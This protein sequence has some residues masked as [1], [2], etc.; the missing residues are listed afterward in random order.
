LSSLETLVKGA[1]LAT[2][3]YFHDINQVTQKAT[4]LTA[5]LDT[6]LVLQAIGLEGEDRQTMVRELLELSRDLGIATACFEE[7]RTELRG[8][9]KAYQKTYGDPGRWERPGSA[10]EWL[11]EHGRTTSDVEIMI[12]QLDKTLEAAGISVLRRPATEQDDSKTQS[13]E[14][15]IDAKVH[16][17]EART[18]RRDALCVQAIRQL[19]AGPRP[20]PFESAKAVFVSQNR[21]LVK[22]VESYFGLQS[23][24]DQT[25]YCLTDAEF[26]TLLWCKSPAKDPDLPSRY[27]I[28]DSFAS[29]GPSDTLWRAYIGE[30]EKLKTEAGIS[31]DA[32][33]VLRFSKPAR[34]ALM[35]ATS[36]EVDVFTVGT[37]AEVQRRMD[38]ASRAESE[39]RAR[40]QENLRQAAEQQAEK[41][42]D[43]V[44][45]VRRNSDQ[46]ADRIGLAF[47]RGIGVGLCLVCLVGLILTWPASLGSPP[48]GYLPLVAPVAF[49]AVL[50]W[51]GLS[52]ASALGGWSLRTLMA[53]VSGAVAGLVRGILRAALFANTEDKEQP[54]ESPPDANPIPRG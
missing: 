21:G 45:Q 36:G 19:R 53:A 49:V 10:F 52:L 18:R 47:S 41:A 5:Y 1:M 8:I 33:Y 51:S 40:A 39:E 17:M 20:L 38:A 37:V 34:R 29:L 25:P 15:A 43:V 23:G 3:L 22:G 54:T 12:A 31:I 32:Y 7:T 48:G 13:L 46:L 27:V 24:P 4:D 11:R 2:A 30:L 28:A 50:A 6:A 9:L 14:K 26:V 44:D 35:D 16:Y 42:R